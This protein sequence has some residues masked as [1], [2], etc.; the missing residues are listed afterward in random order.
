MPRYNLRSGKVRAAA[1]PLAPMSIPDSESERARVK[2]GLLYSR[3]VTL[4]SP[5]VGLTTIEEA[6]P[7][8]SAPMASTTPVGS[9]TSNIFASNPDD[10]VEESAV[11]QAIKDE[12][13]DDGG[14]PWTPVRCHRRSKS[15]DSP[16]REYGSA[17]ARRQ[18]CGASPSPV[19]DTSSRGE[20]P[21]KDKGKTVDPLNW[22]NV[23]IDPRELNPDAQRRE[24]EGY[25][26]RQK[27]NKK[28]IQ[29]LSAAG[30]QDRLEQ[31]REAS[32]ENDSTELSPSPR[33]LPT[34]IRLQCKTCVAISG[35]RRCLNKVAKL[36]AEISCLR[37]SSSRASSEA[38]TLAGQHLEK[39]S[40]KVTDSPTNRAAARTVAS[41]APATSRPTP[42][43]A[44]VGKAIRRTRAVRELSREGIQESWTPST[45]RLGHGHPLIS[46]FVELRR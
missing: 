21:S 27:L 29:Q 9:P 37:L 5:S 25:A 18:T 19:S 32:A 1:A 12:E 38:P 39:S 22:G 13:L 3:A 36:E 7:E 28:Y 14:G 31:W 8:P 35:R 10:V 33:T 43:D 42:A 40:E 24:L 46:V 45:R 6:S 23:G 4:R 34:R 44:L 2:P 11:E 17:V 15:W 41:V 20:G 26:S 16:I 30:P